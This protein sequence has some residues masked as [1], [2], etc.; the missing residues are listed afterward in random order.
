MYVPVGSVNN[1]SVDFKATITGTKTYNKVYEYRP[2]NK[3]VQEIIPTYLYPTTKTVNTSINFNIFKS[4]VVITK[5]DKS[6]NKQLAGATL[7]LKDSKGGVVTSWKTTGSA[8]VIE[9]LPKGTYTIQE[10][11]APAGYELNTTSLKF[12]ISDTNRTAT[13]T[14]YNHKKENNKGSLKIIKV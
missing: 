3:N 10:T 1:T 5:V 7:V 13:L 11:A 2:S 4:K 9:N 14:F 12:T 8:H 6:T